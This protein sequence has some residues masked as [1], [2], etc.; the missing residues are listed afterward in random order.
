MLHKLFHRIIIHLFAITIFMLT[1][2][3]LFSSQ[4]LSSSFTRLRRYA[5][6][7]YLHLL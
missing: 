4:S 2:V 5:E 1:L 6:A 7:I 3:L